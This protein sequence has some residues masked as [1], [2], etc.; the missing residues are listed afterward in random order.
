[1]DAFGSPQRFPPIWADEVRRAVADP[2]DLWSD[3]TLLNFPDA[4]T[5]LLAWLDDPRVFEPDKHRAALLSAFSDYDE[6]LRTAVGAKV[7]T[8]LKAKLSDVARHLAGL[9][10]ASD[11][12]PLKGAAVTA[13]KT[14][15]DR[16]VD[17][18]ILQAGWRDLCK[19]CEGPATTADLIA[20]R[21][22][23]FFLLARRAGHNMDHLCRALAGVLSDDPL[24]VFTAR[25]NIGEQDPSDSG[26]IAHL[27][28]GALAG[29]KVTQQRDLCLRMLALPPQAASHVVWLAFDQAYLRDGV[30]RADRVIFFD[31]ERLPREPDE[32][33]LAYAPRVPE[34][35]EEDAIAMARELPHA[36]GVVLARVELPLG[37]YADPVAVATDQVDALVTVAT[38]HTGNAMQDGWRLMAGYSHFSAGASAWRRF[39][40]TSGTRRRR[41]DGVH[42]EIDKIASKV[43]ARL[44]VA[45]ESVTQT[46]EILRWW[47]RARE[48]SSPASVILYVR[49]LELLASRV[50]MTPWERYLREYLRAAWIHHTM[51][52]SV[53]DIVIG[54]VS[55]DSA[56]LPEQEW[57]RLMAL[58]EQVLDV[59]DDMRVM[60]APGSTQAALAELL[61]IYP[62]HHPQ[63]RRVRSL[64]ARL[65]DH[66]SIVAWQDELAQRWIHLVGRLGRARNAITHGGPVTSGAVDT[67]FDFS[68]R[69]AGWGVTLALEAAMDGPD[70]VTAHTDFRKEFDELYTDVRTGQDPAALLHW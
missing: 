17:P 28:P 70:L 21:R 54:A 29:L 22:E 23:L 3:A 35:G 63:G 67:I 1:M 40:G 6:A 38:F 8:A 65:Q 30:L 11:P 46:L 19:A 26:G 43:F 49:V 42:Q 27:A 32:V 7:K 2:Q 55:G 37:V 44:S 59:D 50:H 14:L 15:M 60:L 64:A 25:V 18:V 4:V 24:A 47:R 31:S 66:A 36:K 56:G 53:I 39:T 69:L 16:L 5:E 12:T 48:Q 52:D 68:Y 13:V 33:T 41:L 61:S 62:L 57:R 10:T 9:R 51:R 34:L 58:R 20:V 45:E